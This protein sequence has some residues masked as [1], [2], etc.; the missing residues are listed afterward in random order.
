MFPSRHV[1]RCSGLTLLLG[2]FWP[3]E[4]YI[5]RY[6]RL[7]VRSLHADCF[8]WTCRPDHGRES[9]CGHRHR[10]NCSCHPRVSHPT[11]HIMNVVG[12]NL[13]NNCRFS[14]IAE[15]APPSIRGRLV[16]FYEIGSQGAQMCG[17]WVNY[18]VNK[19]ISSSSKSIMPERPKIPMSTTDSVQHRLN[20]RFL[21][22][23]NC[24]P[25]SLFSQ[26]CLS[27]QNHHGGWLRRTLGRKPRRSFVI[28]ASCPPV[29]LMS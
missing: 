11:S 20:G 17:F 10:W 13:P 14:Y 24:S 8:K 18:A 7:H 1:L 26:S 4:V 2:A 28:F 9:D 6:R 21:L 22:A 16:G 15:V 25:P 27:A 12:I 29:T 23:F 3:Q 5:L 19:T